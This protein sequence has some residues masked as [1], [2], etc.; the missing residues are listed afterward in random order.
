VTGLSAVVVVPREGVRM[1]CGGMSGQRALCRHRVEAGGCQ[2][3]LVGMGAQHGEL[4][5][6]GAIAE[7]VR[8]Q[9]LRAGREPAQAGLHAEWGA[10]GGEVKRHGE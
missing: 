8:R 2:Q 7:A 4:L 6:E 10:D 9:L 5:D 1:F 3:C